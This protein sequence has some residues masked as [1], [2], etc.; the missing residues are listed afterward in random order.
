[1]NTAQEIIESLEN[2]PTVAREG[3]AFVFVAE[4]GTKFI[5]RGDISQCTV[6][7]GQIQFH[8]EKA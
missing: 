1:M 4:D 6:E 2:I 8:I 7:H 3:M 5:A